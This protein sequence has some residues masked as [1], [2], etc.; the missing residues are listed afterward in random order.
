M[1]GIKGEIRYEGITFNVA[2]REW[3][4]MQRR[5]ITGTAEYHYEQHIPDRFTYAGGKRLGFPARS[6]TYTRIKYKRHGH[7]DPNV[8]SGESKRRATS[9]PPDIRPIATAKRVR[10]RLVLD[11]PALN[12]KNPDSKNNVHPASEVRGIPQFEADVLTRNFDENMQ[13]EIAIVGS[14]HLARKISIGA[15]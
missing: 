2:K 15:I 11:A 14:K 7:G 10:G 8:F 3:N 1:I 4:N 6:R 13:S 12:L 9:G 5:A